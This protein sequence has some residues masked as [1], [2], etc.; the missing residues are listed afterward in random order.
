MCVLQWTVLQYTQTIHLYSWLECVIRLRTVH[1]LDQVFKSELGLQC[2]VSSIV[3][4]HAHTHS[5]AHT[6]IWDWGKGEHLEKGM[7]DACAQ[8]VALAQYRT[9][10]VWTVEHNWRTRHVI[11]LLRQHQIDNHSRT[12][13]WQWENR[14]LHCISIAPAWLWYYRWTCLQANNWYT[15]TKTCAL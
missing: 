4:A 2:T 13:H 1:E 9:T 12:P 8:V 15:G 7:L 5:A 3:H 14:R 6:H 10:T 11:A